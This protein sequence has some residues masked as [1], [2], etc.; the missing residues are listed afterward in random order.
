[1]STK[2]EVRRPDALAAAEGRVRRFTDWLDM[3]DLFRWFEERRPALFDEQLIR[4][5]EHVENGV[6]TIR[7][8]VPG[9]DP[10]KDAEITIGD[11]VL[12]FRVERRQEETSEGRGRY[13]SEFRYGSFSRSVPLPADTNPESVTASY[14][15]GILEVRVPV[16]EGEPERVT[17]PVTKV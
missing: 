12:R 14:R 17:V 13:R 7:A 8:E 2:L 11:G 16:P 5:E 9:I 1:M 15:D 10:E 6:L 3:P 4:V